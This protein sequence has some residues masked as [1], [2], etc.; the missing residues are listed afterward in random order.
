MKQICRTVIVFVLVLLCHFTIISSVWAA[1][2]G[3]FYTGIFGAF[4]IPEDLDIKGQSREIKLDDSWAV[5][6]KIGY[7]F[8]AVPWLAAELEYTY[9][10]QQDSDDPRLKVNMDM[11]NFM[12][13]VL[14]RYPAGRIHPFTGIGIGC[15]WGELNRDTH[16]DN[17]VDFAWQLM[18]G[19]NFEITQT[20]STDIAYRYFTSE[21]DGDSKRGFEIGDVVSK[22]HMFVLGVNY[23]F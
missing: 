21:W 4:V 12:A 6:A 13:N 19:V 1:D 10:A 11:H 15:S 17:A 8:S 23:C 3:R 16:E 22:N 7:N 18:A 20:W 2:A 14:I 5:G 9:L